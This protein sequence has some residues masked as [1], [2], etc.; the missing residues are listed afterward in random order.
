MM[1]AP[2][3]QEADARQRTADI[4]V[5]PDPPPADTA[6]WR[7]LVDGLAFALQPIVSIHTGICLGFETL[8]RHTDAAGY[9][10][11]KHFFDAAYAD[12]M[13]YTVDV[14]LREKAL[15]T[16][17]SLAFHQ[18]CRLF[19][20]IDNRVL[21]MPDYHPGNTVRLLE[22][23]Q[24]SPSTV[25]FELS[26]RHQ[27]ECFNSI[28]ATL[29]MYKQ[30][31]F[32]IA[33]DDFGS[34][35]SG[36]QLLYHAEPDYIKIDRFFIAGIA[37]D[38]KKRLFVL[39]VLSLAHTLG[40]AV[41]AEGVESADEFYVCKDIGCD[42]VQ[43]YLIQE[44][45]LDTSRLSLRYDNVPVLGR[46]ERR[47]HS[48]DHRIITDQMEYI[49]PIRID[50]TN[51]TQ[52]FDRFRSNKA[53]T[54][55]P[56]VNA[57]DEPLGL[58]MEKDL[59]EYA[60]SRYGKDLLLN[61]GLSKTLLDFISRCPAADVHKNL[62]EIL[63]IYAIDERSEGII[64]TGGGVYIGFMST[65]AL[66]KALNE[67]N[68]ALARDQNPL[69]K[70]P[71]NNLI[72]AYIAETAHDVRN[73]YVYAYFDFDHFKPFN[74]SYGFRVGDRAILL[75]AD[76]LKS[77]A[78]GNSFIGHIGGDDFFSGI[79]LTDQNSELILPRTQLLI[80]R[81]GE[82]IMA[83]YRPQDRKNGYL[84]GIDRDGTP[85]RFPLLSVSAAILHLPKN[86]NPL[87]LEEISQR[88]AQLKK[89][90]KLAAT[91]IKCAQV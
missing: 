57:K 86:R 32:R 70:L 68:I 72:T 58:I 3:K 54:F 79:R 26:E 14:W 77:C 30:Q 74:D 89:E 31:G 6:P 51:M 84:D 18:K 50:R 36:L 60:Y 47:R 87:S 2:S 44:P 43:G 39:K 67:K 73:A 35:F 61:A 64:L 23:H 38:P 27:F 81:F 80:R 11:I 29:I 10:A 24:L 20:N 63:D 17:K 28:K 88:M 25:C 4:V 15:N 41:I 12:R 85:R 83:F 46:A 40:I 21:Q 78:N 66:L 53:Q 49:E 1:P 9:S 71:G 42:Y 7:A 48:S 75:F 34:G 65:R 59:K 22:Q 5:F 91:G 16:F 19:Y 69:T 62:E 90:A 82:D 52:V 55:I 76:L 56:V 37:A 45:Q 33:I 13:L 8:L